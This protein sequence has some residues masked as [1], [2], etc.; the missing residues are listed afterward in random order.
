MIECSIKGCGEFCSETLNPEGAKHWIRV[1]ACQCGAY[2]LRTPKSCTCQSD[3][4]DVV[5][6][7]Y[8]PNLDWW[9]F[10]GVEEI[11][12]CPTHRREVLVEIVGQ[13]NMDPSMNPTAQNRGNVH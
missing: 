13:R 7:S 10:G 4:S 5:Q 11:I 8:W 3:P 9:M 2:D 1:R 12:L 6:T